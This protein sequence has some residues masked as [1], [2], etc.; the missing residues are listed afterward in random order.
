[1]GE[2]LYYTLGLLLCPEGVCEFETDGYPNYL[3]SGHLTRTGV[4]CK[5]CCGRTPMETLE[6]GK[7][8]WQEKL[9]A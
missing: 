8:I 7:S 9:V 3:D 1:M 6:D 5:K 2:F 4:E